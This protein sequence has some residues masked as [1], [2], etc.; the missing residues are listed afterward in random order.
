[1]E[2]TVNLEYRCWFFFELLMLL[3][4]NLIIVVVYYNIVLNFSQFTCS[5]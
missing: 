5:L 3:W 2:M 1:M 4:D